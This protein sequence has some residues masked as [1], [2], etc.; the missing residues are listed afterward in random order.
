MK[1]IKRSK[2]DLIFDIINYTILSMVLVLVL[3]PLYFIVIAS[4]SEPQA[5]NNGQVWLLPKGITFEGYKRIL[6]DSRIWT[7]YLNTLIYTVLG[8]AINI[9][10]TMMIAYPLS[11]KD[12]S[13]RKVLTIFLIITMYFGGGMI[14]TYLL[15]KQIGLLNKWPVMVVMG[16]VSV[17][18]VIIAR[19]FIQGNIPDELYESASIDGCTQ[20]GY[21]IK[22]IL[23]L[24]KPIMAVLTLYYGIGHWNEYM[25]S[26]I[27][28]SNEKLYPLQMILRSILIINSVDGNMVTDVVEEMERQR[29]GELIKYGVIIVSSLPVL[30]LYPFLQKYFVKGT[31]VGA[32]KG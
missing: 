5:I 1:N 24:S 23:P 25:K 3:Y 7:G 29:A 18:N 20:F 8:T 19:S 15:V 22:F 21:F 11:R 31:M 9:I 27:Y 28:L 4:I 10:L 26:L 13:G 17:F 14:P 6:E 32:V 12:F 30:V 16:A 2:E